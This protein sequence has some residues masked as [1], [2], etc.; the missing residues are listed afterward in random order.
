M[1]MRASMLNYVLTDP[2]VR[3][4][5]REMGFTDEE[6]PDWVPEDSDTHLRGPDASASD[7]VLKPVEASTHRL[8]LTYA[9][10]FERR[11]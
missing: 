7:Y 6:L 3:V 4:E 9:C 8:N 2:M 1:N 5:L 11:I 10:A